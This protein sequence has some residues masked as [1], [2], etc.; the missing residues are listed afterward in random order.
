MQKPRSAGDA[1]IRAPPALDFSSLPPDDA[2]TKQLNNVRGMVE[3]GWPAL[4]VSLSF[5]I[6]SNLSEELFV[7]VLSGIQNLTNVA[8]IL[9]LLTPRD[10]FL[11]CV[12][13]FAVPSRVVSSLDSS[14]EP[15]TPRSAGVLS[16]ESLGLSAL[17]GTSAQPPGLSERNL[18]CLKALISIALFLAGSLGPTWF[19][20]LETLQNAEYVLVLRASRGA[21]VHNRKNSLAPTPMSPS[22]GRSASGPQPPSNQ[23]PQ[24]NRHPLLSDLD[25]DSIQA[26]I[27]RLFDTSKSLD[28]QAFKHFIASLCKLSAAMVGMQ[29]IEEE[30]PEGR[31]S[32][33]AISPSVSSP[34]SPTKSDQR[35]RAS[36]IHLS[37]TM[38]S[39]LSIVVLPT[40]NLLPCSAPGITESANLELSPF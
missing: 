35:R 8:G 26:A 31:P 5:L 2:S 19:D 10:A 12:A 36:G 22:K 33:D 18:A 32:E 11:T 20:V 13:K 7:D 38:V 9:G 40:S 23:I 39:Y 15:A 14:I 29:Y 21:P 3:S 27:N 4:L 1:V 6:A 24:Q 16:A 25:I 34:L 17:T 30:G 37:R 28:D